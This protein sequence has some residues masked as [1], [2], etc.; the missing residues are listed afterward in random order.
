VINERLTQAFCLAVLAAVLVWDVLCLTQPGRATV[1]EVLKDWSDQYRIVPCA[2]AFCMG[3]AF[4]WR[5]LPEVI[6]C[7][8]CGAWVWPTYG[9]GE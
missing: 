8:A 4:G 7:Y 3:H 9:K 6:V 5:V 2:L 1:S